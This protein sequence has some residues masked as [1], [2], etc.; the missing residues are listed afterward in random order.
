MVHV[1]RNV[2]GTK[3]SPRRNCLEP[4]KILIGADVVPK[5]LD[6][7]FVDK[8][9]LLRQRLA[10][11][12][13][14]LPIV[15]IMDQH[16]IGATEFYVL[17]YENVL[18]KESLN[19]IGEETVDYIVQKLEETVRV[20]YAEILNSDIIKSLADNLKIRTV[21]RRNWQK[22]YAVP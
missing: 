3:I 4:L 6:N 13:I 1:L 8:I 14:M 11:E 15:R 5:F 9:S 2:A 21:A 20:K 7:R 10:P 18:Y 22:Q 12:G 17:A 19:E 16:M